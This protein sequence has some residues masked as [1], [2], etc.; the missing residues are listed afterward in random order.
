[1]GGAT[2]QPHKP[3]HRVDG[4][5]ALNEAAVSGYAIHCGIGTGAALTR[6]LLQQDDGRALG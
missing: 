6:P 3:L 5:L 4:R 2:L 1:M